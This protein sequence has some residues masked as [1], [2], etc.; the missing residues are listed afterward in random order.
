MSSYWAELAYSGAPGKG[1]DVEQPEWRPWDNSPGE[2]DKFI[3]FDTPSDGGIRMSSDTIGLGT[4]RD[5]L[6]AETGFRTQEKHCE[7]YVIALADSE[8]WSDEEYANLGRE[9]CGSY[10]KQI[11]MR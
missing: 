4:V 11:Y 7:M 8:L 3:I 1:R 9:G 2:R 5:R 6:L 10:P